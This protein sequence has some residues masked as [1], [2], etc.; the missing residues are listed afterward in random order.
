[1]ASQKRQSTDVLH[2]NYQNDPVGQRITFE[3]RFDS[4]FIVFEEFVKEVER[5]K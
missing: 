1:M 4:Q 3:E 2:K 5:E